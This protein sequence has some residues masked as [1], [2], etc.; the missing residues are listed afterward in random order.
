MHAKKVLALALLYAAGGRINGRTRFQKLAFLAEQRLENY[1]IHTYE[2]EAYDY[3]PF[4]KSLYDELDF[5]EEKGLIHC[6]EKPTYGGDTR[7][8]YKLTE[9]G[10]QVFEQNLPRDPENTSGPDETDQLSESDKKL[11]QLY[12][13]AR[14]VANEY[15]DVP[16]SNLLDYV[17]SEYPKYAENSVLY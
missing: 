6:I 13:I 14:D 10:R 9:K 7:Y 5:L 4:C 3:G 2:F 11:W 15:N 12:A 16:I 17:Y 1:G 8:D